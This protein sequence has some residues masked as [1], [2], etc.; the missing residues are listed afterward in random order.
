LAAVAE[1]EVG[2]AGGAKVADVNIFGE[3]AGGEELRTVGFAE[4]EMNVFGRG[5]VAG[6][7][8]IEPLE[9]I[10]FFAGERLIE[11]VGGIGELG[12]EFGDEIGGDFVAAR[13]DGRADGGEKIRRV[14]AKFELHA[15]DGF[16]GY[17]GERAAPAGV[18]GGNGA[19]FGIDEQDG[20]AIS[21]LNGEKKAGAIG[22]GGIAGAGIRGA[23]RENV[24]DVRM[25]LLERNEIKSRGAEGGLEF[26]TIGEDVF[27]SV[28]FHKTEVENFFRIERTDA[29]G[30]GA[31]AVDEP[32][33]FGEWGELEDLQAA[34]FTETPRG[35][36]AS[37]LRRRGRGLAGTSAHPECF[38]GRHNQTSIIARGLG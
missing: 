17:A 12:G 24:D 32:G 26:A 37:S 29:A 31:E 25:D 22:G 19:F 13:T 10:G 7:L 15:A 20:D 28:P 9:G 36:N 2:V 18:N 38:F 30:A 11:I 14:A 27:A 35:A 34:C 16:L 4:I 33:Q 3:Q 6:R 23:L 21:G 8:H 5:L 1:E